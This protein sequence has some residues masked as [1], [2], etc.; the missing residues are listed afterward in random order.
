MIQCFFS[1]L[2][3][4]KLGQNMPALPLPPTLKLPPIIQKYLF[5]G[6]TS[7]FQFSFLGLQMWNLCAFICVL[8]VSG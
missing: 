4:S 6:T 2:F 3:L 8:S 1:S 7:L 5:Y